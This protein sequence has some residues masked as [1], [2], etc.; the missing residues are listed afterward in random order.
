MHDTYLE[1]TFRRGTPLA[2]YCHLPRRP[3]QKSVR[4]LEAAP[5]LL[6]D[7]ARGGKPLGIEILAP[8]RVTVTAINRVLR[9][10]GQPVLSRRDLAPLRA[11]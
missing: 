10:L 1:V 11:S 7:F 5:G 4:T 9:S 3:G 2:A 6:V 8:D